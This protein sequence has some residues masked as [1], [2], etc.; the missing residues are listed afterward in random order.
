MAQMLILSPVQRMTTLVACVA[1]LAVSIQ[2]TK[3]P[4]VA[5]WTPPLSMDSTSRITTLFHLVVVLADATRVGLETLAPLPTPPPEAK[6]WPTYPLLDPDSILPQNSVALRIRTLTTRQ[7][8]DQERP[9]LR[10][11]NLPLA[12]HHS[13]RWMPSATRSR[14]SRMRTKRCR[15]TPL[16]SW[17][18]SSP[19]KVSSMSLP[20]TTPRNQSPHP[21]YP[22]R[23]LPLRPRRNLAH[24]L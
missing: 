16:R 7:A 15:C 22:V 11:G 1:R 19:R 2:W 6:L 3:P 14:F 9:R 10:T 17:I 5:P 23:T 8:D 12:T 13:P 20:S 18:V 24:N 4:K 21:L